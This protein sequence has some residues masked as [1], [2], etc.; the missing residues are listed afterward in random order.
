MPYKVVLFDKR[1]ISINDRFYSLESLGSKKALSKI[2][3]QVLRLAKIYF[4]VDKELEQELQRACDA[5]AT[6]AQAHRQS[7]KR[8]VS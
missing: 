8:D 6:R 3:M 7:Q 5:F 1:N 2:E 4:G